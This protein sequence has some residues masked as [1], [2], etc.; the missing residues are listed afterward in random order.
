[1]PEVMWLL[2]VI[3]WVILAIHFTFQAKF[4]GMLNLLETFVFELVVAFF[5]ISCSGIKFKKRIELLILILFG[6]LLFWDIYQNNI[7]WLTIVKD[8]IE[9]FKSNDELL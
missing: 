7:I 5:I 9:P 3:S 8:K 1:M 4:V 6:C 2:F